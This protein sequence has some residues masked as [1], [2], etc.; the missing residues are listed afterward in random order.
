MMTVASLRSSNH[1]TCN[2]CGTLLVAPEF[3]EP[4]SEEQVVIDCWSC[5]NCGNQFETVA[6]KSKVDSKVA[7]ELHPWLLVA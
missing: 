7:K 1:A 3:S 2:K 5:V 4:F 6:A